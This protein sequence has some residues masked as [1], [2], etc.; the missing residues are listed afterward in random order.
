MTITTS[1]TPIDTLV[2]LLEAAGFKVSLL[3]WVD[4]E[5]ELHC[6]EWDAVMDSSAAPPI[7]MDARPMIRPTYIDHYRCGQ[8]GRSSHHAEENVRSSLETA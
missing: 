3:E 6:R 4:E 5:G 1:S 7:T 2:E 8:A